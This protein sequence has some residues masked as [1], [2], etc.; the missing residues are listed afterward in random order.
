MSRHT[1]S[2]ADRLYHGNSVNPTFEDGQR[3]VPMDPLVQVDLGAPLTLDVDGL[4][5][6]ATGAELPN[7]ATIVYTPLTGGVSPL[8]GAN[9]SWVLDVPRNITI[10][11]TH[12][13]A[14]IAMTVLVTGKDK[15]GSRM[16][17][18]LSISAGGTSQAATGKKAFK[19]VDSIA[20]TAAG[21]ATTNTMNLGWGDVLGLPFKC[22]GKFDMVSFY[23]DTTAEL[24]TSTVVAG[25]DT[26]P[27]ATTG[28]VR[29]T[30]VP[31]TATNG[32]RR[33]RAWY[34]IA[35]TANNAQAF[36]RAQYAG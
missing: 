5:L 22:A 23:M 30:I 11:T 29:G 15:Y 6:A 12:G 9:Q 17:E 2:H 25:D 27:S 14:V 33:Y 20:I 26:T 10:A 35:G 8:D 19:S 3:G 7:A 24:A 18:Q 36:G 34:K 28:D 1:I 16:V 32:T 13:S 31:A 21:N 4:I